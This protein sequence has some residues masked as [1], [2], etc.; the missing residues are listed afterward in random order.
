MTPEQ[1]AAFILAQTQMMVAE[2]D[3][4][5]AENIEREQQ[6]MAPANGPAEWEKMRK[7]WESTLGYNAL[8]EFFYDHR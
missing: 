1:K 5:I 7:N 6:G 8:L 3:V 2:R 4:M